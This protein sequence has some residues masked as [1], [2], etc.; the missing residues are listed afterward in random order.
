MRMMVKFQMECAA[1]NAAIKSGALPK[2]MKSF[3]EERRPEAAYF[4]AEGGLRTAYFFIDL[5]DVSEIPQVVEPFFMGVNAAA[6]ITPAMN[7]EDLG[8]GLEAWAK[9]AK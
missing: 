5:K 1:A 8:K 6:T 9:K 7:A 4:L 3:M 2:L